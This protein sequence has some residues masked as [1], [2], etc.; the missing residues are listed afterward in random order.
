MYSKPRHQVFLSREK[1][2]IEFSFQPFL[3]PYAHPEC[4]FGCIFSSGLT[5]CL[6]KAL[7]LLYQAL[8]LTA[9]EYWLFFLPLSNTNHLNTNL[10]R[11]LAL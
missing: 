4:R 3:K 6:K 8:E 7:S 2:S 9:R 1:L 11:V 5:Y 10:K